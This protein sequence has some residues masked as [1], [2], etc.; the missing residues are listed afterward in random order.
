M[1]DR[2]IFIGI[3]ILGLLP[4]L[5][6]LLGAVLGGRVPPPGDVI[7]GTSLPT[8]FWMRGLERCRFAPSAAALTILALSMLSYIGSLIWM[9]RQGR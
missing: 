9:S 8:S 5:L 7:G 2:I 3:A 1:R 6:V 4:G